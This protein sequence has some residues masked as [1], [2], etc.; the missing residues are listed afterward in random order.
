M[1]YAVID[2]RTGKRIQVDI[3]QNSIPA[4]A[5]KKLSVTKED[6][7]QSNS[8]GS[9]SRPEDELEAGIRVYDPGSVLLSSSPSLQLFA[10]RET[11]L[12]WFQVHEYGGDQE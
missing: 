12:A 1:M 7:H 4:T 11:Q 2:N 6:D 5:L 9:S 8:K 10:C 3:E